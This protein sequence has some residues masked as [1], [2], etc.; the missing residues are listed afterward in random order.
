MQATCALVEFDG[1]C[2][3]ISLVRFVLF[4]SSALLSRISFATLV[5]VS[6][7]D[8]HPSSDQHKYALLKHLL[9]MLHQLRTFIFRNI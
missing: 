2:H 7:K 9:V 3:S 4:Y 1:F 5:V 6:A 8:C